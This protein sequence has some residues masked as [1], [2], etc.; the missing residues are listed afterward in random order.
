MK[1]LLSIIVRWIVAVWM[2]V[3][4][5]LSPAP[6]APPDLDMYERATVFERQGLAPA[7]TFAEHRVNPSAF[8]VRRLIGKHAPRDERGQARTAAP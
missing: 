7:L 2:M 3:G 4:S 5:W 8:A 1:S 6:A